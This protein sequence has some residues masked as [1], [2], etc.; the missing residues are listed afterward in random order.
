M[1]LTAFVLFAIELD[2]YCLPSFRVLLAGSQWPPNEWPAIS[3]F[4]FRVKFETCSFFWSFIRSAGT[5]TDYVLY[6]F[7]LVL[8]ILKFLFVIVLFHGL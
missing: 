2:F 8:P 3:E 6:L 4:D 5:K 1:R 7:F